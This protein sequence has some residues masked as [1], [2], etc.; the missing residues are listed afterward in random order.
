MLQHNA[1][2]IGQL[3][4]YRLFQANAARH[5]ERV[6]VIAPDGVRSYAE[7]DADVTRLAAALARLGIAAGE[8]LAL[9]LDRGADAVTALLASI[10]LGATFVAMDPAFPAA[11]LAAM[12]ADCQPRLV[13]HHERHV[14]SLADWDQPVST[15][16]EACQLAGD[17]SAPSFVA[18]GTAPMYVIYTSG[19]TGQPKGIV[20][21]F[22]TIRNLVRWENDETNIRFDG[23]VLQNSSLA[24]DV[25]LQEILSTLTAGGTLVVSS[26]DER[27]DPDLMVD[28]LRRQR[29]NVVFFSVSTLTRLFATPERLGT[30]PGTLTDIVTAGEQLYLNDALRAYLLANPRLRLHNHYGVSESHVVTA[31]T[32]SGAMGEIPARM[33]IG[34]PVAGA[35]V[36][37]RRA[38]GSAARPGEADETGEIVITG[39]CLALG[40]LNRPEEQ[41][42]RFVIIDDK[43]HYVTGDLAFQH[44]G[45][46]FE[47]VGRADQQLKIRGHLVEPSDVEAAL[48]QH[49]AIAE[50][51]VDVLV[52]TDGEHQL[53]VWYTITADCPQRDLRAHLAGLLPSFM[54]PSRFQL[55][56]ALPVTATGKIDRG[57]LRRHAGR[58]ESSPPSNAVGEGLEQRVLAILR[59]VLESPDL[60][61]MTRF[62]DAGATSLTLVRAA[63]VLS[64]ELN[65]QLRTVDLFRFPSTAQLTAEICRRSGAGQA[66]NR[67]TTTGQPAPAPANRGLDEPLAVIG[68]AGRF[69]GAP[70]VHALWRMLI[71]G[72]HGLTPHPGGPTASWWIPDLPHPEGP[73][74]MVGLLADAYHFEPEFF[75]YSEREAEWTD[76]QQRLLLMC[77]YAALESGGHPPSQGGHVGVYVGGEF[78]GYIA[79]VRPHVQSMGDYLQAL[80]GND[81]DFLAT[82]VA[83]KL[84]LTGPA[85]T[86]QTACSTSLVAVHLAR[87][88]LLL[89]E[90]DLA[91]AG[92]VSLQFPQEFG[93]RHEE[94]L[95]YSP[96]GMTRPFDK[97]AAGT[98]ITSGV[99]LVV[100]KRLTDAIEDGDT[101]LA[102]ICGTAIN[103]DGADKAGYTAPS[104]SGQA[105][106]IRDS[107]RA[108]G[109]TP[110]DIDFV[111]G[112]GTATPLG[113]AI[114]VAALHDVFGVVR[115]K[116]IQLGSIKGNIGH[117]NR[118][119]G[120]AGLI[121][122]V[123]AMHH[124]LL[125]GTV[126][127]CQPGPQLHLDD[128][129]FIVPTKPVQLRADGQPSRAGVSSFGFGGTNAHVVVEQWSRPS[130]PEVTDLPYLLTL[131]ADR[132][133]QLTALAAELA[134]HLDANPEI[135]VADAAYTRNTGHDRRALTVPGRG[136]PTRPTDRPAAGHRPGGRSAARAR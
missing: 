65:T 108:A 20:Q 123:L 99:G 47:F 66:S 56:A 72:R 4:L 75:G 57:A 100:L 119:A 79:N 43:R 14:S 125:P 91:L 101:I 29:V 112:H 16:T 80:I 133:D 87:Q 35:R 110:A 78:P 22:Q 90:C 60:E 115:D 18:A 135:T 36:Y 88:A 9:L 109:L 134:E 8:R 54:V 69:P 55:L 26:E 104:A 34:V 33:P 95:I 107:L 136:Q 122:A 39:E 71:D 82:R 6:A 114:E 117:T 118:A 58:Q 85:I 102:L 128:G 76:P 31:H 21:T 13:L 74:P 19:S 23:R 32:I 15:L 52:T 81:K 121:K 62:F 77:A 41:E 46:V 37:L 10:R 130:S 49:S 51:A 40:Y 120:I 38:D 132:A 105:R 61:P 17:I 96:D 42:K 113:D 11:R 92:G 97:A 93:N 50:C 83:H 27:L 5:P 67:E 131:T 24:F 111:E 103:N 94:G 12:L 98:N 53:A 7:L 48:R 106:V 129:P 2:R 28:L 70:D 86:V 30:L 59:S 1:D 126:G 124:G 64:G 89:G 45:G 3:C 84:N 68:I 116:R 127:H 63:Q 25:S 73:P 44:P